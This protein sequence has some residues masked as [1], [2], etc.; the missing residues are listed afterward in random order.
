MLKDGKE[1]IHSVMRILTGERP[2]P[3]WSGV[4]R[5][6]KCGVPFRFNLRSDPK[7]LI[8]VRLPVL[9]SSDYR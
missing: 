7:G 8:H 4:L 5:C 2:V 3:T 1:T 6:S 9:S